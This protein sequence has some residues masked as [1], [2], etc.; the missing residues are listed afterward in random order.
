M[1][2]ALMSEAESEELCAMFPTK[3]LDFYFFASSVFCYSVKTVKCKLEASRL[4]ASK[5][6]INSFTI[7]S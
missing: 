7:S 3:N 6:S 5:H 1:R 2:G 4:S